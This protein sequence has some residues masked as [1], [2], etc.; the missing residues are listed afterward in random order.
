MSF[1]AQPAYIH[2]QC[3]SL[4]IGWLLDG[5]IKPKRWTKLTVEARIFAQMWH[6]YRGSSQIQLGIA[7][8]SDTRFT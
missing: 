8:V 7:G 1:L 5:D 3:G 2:F 6:L 4:L